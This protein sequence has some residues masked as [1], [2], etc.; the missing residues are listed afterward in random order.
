MKP[1]YCPYRSGYLSLIFQVQQ[2]GITH[3]TPAPSRPCAPNGI[4]AVGCI[5]IG[6][7]I[8]LVIGGISTSSSRNILATPNT[9]SSRTIR[10]K[11]CNKD[12]RFNNNRVKT[13]GYTF[14]Q[15]NE[16]YLKKKYNSF[17]KIY[18]DLTF[19]QYNHILAIFTV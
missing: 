16:L 15:K 12:K 4:L 5:P 1:L 8:I 7:V 13:D 17:I 9:S 11:S 2:L 3:L 6:S 19:S 18:S 10:S 14:I